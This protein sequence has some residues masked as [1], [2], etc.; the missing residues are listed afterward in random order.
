MGVPTKTSRQMWT[1]RQYRLG[2]VTVMDIG[3]RRDQDPD[4]KKK[5]KKNSDLE[6][7]P[8]CKLSLINILYTMEKPIIT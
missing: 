7:E 4:P 1:R 6:L 8:R 5:K 2:E 3:G